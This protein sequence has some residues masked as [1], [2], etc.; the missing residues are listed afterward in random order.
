MSSTTA[1]T[2][3][4]LPLA[5]QSGAPKLAVSERRI[6]DFRVDSVTSGRL[7]IEVK[8]ALRVP[9]EKAF[10]LVLKDLG[11]WFKEIGNISWN[12]E[13]SDKGPNALAGC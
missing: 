12:H 6:G 5:G 3:A 8:F 9:Q 10:E 7:Q 2:S 13:R 4:V 1:E 11:S